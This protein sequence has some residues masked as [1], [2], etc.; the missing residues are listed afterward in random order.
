[1]SRPSA[2]EVL[3][4]APA[5]EGSNGHFDKLA[6]YFS[7][8]TQIQNHSTTENP[9]SNSKTQPTKTFDPSETP[10]EQLTEFLYQLDSERIQLSEIICNQNVI[11]L[12]EDQLLPH[13]LLR[14][15]LETGHDISPVLKSQR[16]RIYPNSI[17]VDLILDTQA[18]A[19]YPIPERLKKGYSF[20]QS[21][22]PAKN[23]RELYVGF[24][25]FPI[26]DESILSFEKNSRVY[27]GKIP[28]TISSLAENGGANESVNLKSI[29]LSGFKLEE[30]SLTLYQLQN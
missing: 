16:C 10:N 25:L 18:I 6:E 2:E 11:H 3:G 14:A 23:A 7:N 17:E 24:A 13:F 28:F 30:S 8:P 19:Q 26:I 22:I 12:H 21:I 15:F 4:F 5:N 9:N 27:I 29:N 20:F 1:M